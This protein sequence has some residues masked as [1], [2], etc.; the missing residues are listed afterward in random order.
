MTKDEKRKILI[1]FREWWLN[2]T[3][4]EALHPEI[5]DID[6]FLKSINKSL[7]NNKKEICVHPYDSLKQ[8]E[9]GIHCDNCGKQ[10][11]D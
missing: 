1:D 3:D 2:E 5:H 7:G 11:T 6:N 4:G 10:L 9:N 8:D